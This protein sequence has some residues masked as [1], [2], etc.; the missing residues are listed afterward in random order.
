MSG[1]AHEEPIRSK[2]APEA[3]GT[4]RPAPIRTDGI[5]M[6]HRAGTSPDGTEPGSITSH[7]ATVP[8]MGP[9][10]TLKRPIEQKSRLM[11]PKLGL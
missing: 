1:M 2:E 7:R 4:V 5:S 10:L 3:S 6:S 9:N 11:G 8:P